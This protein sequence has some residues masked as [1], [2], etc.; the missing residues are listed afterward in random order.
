[1]YRKIAYEELAKLNQTKPNL[2]VINDIYTGIETIHASDFWKAVW[3]NWS[4]HY[5]TLYKMAAPGIVSC[6]PVYK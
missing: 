4:L 5:I 6:L 1:M 2:F 3:K